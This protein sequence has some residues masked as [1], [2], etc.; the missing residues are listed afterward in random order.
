M[1]MSQK[2]DLP[3]EVMI[4]MNFLASIPFNCLSTVFNTREQRFIIVVLVMM[5]TTTR[6]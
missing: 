2:S 1:C 6:M 3:A 5:M 4:C